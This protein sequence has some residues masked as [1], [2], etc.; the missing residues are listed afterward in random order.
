V[1]ITDGDYKLVKDTDYVIS[2]TNQY[3]VG[4]AVA[5]IK[6]IGSYAGSKDVTYQIKKRTLAQQNTLA[7]GFTVDK[8]ADQKYT[9]YALKPDVVLKDNGKV[10]EQ[11]KDYKLSYKNNTKPGSAQITVTGIGNY[12]GSAKA[13]PFTIV[14]WDY[15]KLQAEIASQVYTGKALKPQVTFTLDGEELNLKVGTAV[16]I[17]Y[18]DNKNA[19]EATAVIT[20]KGVLQ[21]MTPIQVTFTIEQASL[22]DAVVSKI[23]NQTLKGTAATPVPK[24]K[25]GKN[26]LKEGRDFTVSYLRNGVKGQAQVTIKGIGNYTDRCTKTFIVQ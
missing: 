9:G 26:T 25:V 8:V 21:D 10:L 3:N 20:G 19:G 1:T 7:E 23:P 12:T 2:Y 13:I 17:T 18:A 24:V 11:G 6:G 5:T 14:T 4:K 15:T 22:T 16:K